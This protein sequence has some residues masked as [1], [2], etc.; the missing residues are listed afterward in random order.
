MRREIIDRDRTGVNRSTHPM[1]P[2]CEGSDRPP[3]KIP[4]SEGWR[5]KTRSRR[6]GVGWSLSK[7]PLK[8]PLVQGGTLLF[9]ER[10]AARRYETLL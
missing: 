8:F 1:R 4:P 6:A 5:A 2:R 9:I 3:P 7:T 10:G